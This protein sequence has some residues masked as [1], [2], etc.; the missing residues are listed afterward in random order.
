VSRKNS[1]STTAGSG[2]KTDELGLD[3]DHHTPDY[4]G[5]I[6]PEIEERM[7]ALAAAEKDAA[8]NPAPANEPAE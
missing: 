8:G 3:L 2:S 6:P 1:D 7:R 4:A 5:P